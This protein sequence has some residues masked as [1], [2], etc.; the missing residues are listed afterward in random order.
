MAQ[1]VAD[2][3]QGEPGFDV[4]NRKP[5]APEDGTE[6][7]LIMMDADGGLGLP[8]PG[9]AGYGAERVCRRLLECQRQGGLVIDRAEEGRITASSS[10]PSS[11]WPISLWQ[12]QKSPPS[13]Q[14]TSSF[15]LSSQVWPMWLF[16]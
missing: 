14:Q 13:R 7:W 15:W 4:L 8:S 1:A 3:D 6:R 10:R 11:P 2:G 9:R 16:L 5:L 12:R